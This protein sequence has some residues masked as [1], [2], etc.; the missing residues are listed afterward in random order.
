M[1]KK[2]AGI[3]SLA[4]VVSALLTGCGNSSSTT[5]K[6]QKSDTKTET[7]DEK[8]TVRVGVATSGFAYP[9]YIGEEK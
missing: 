5:E 2:I 3:V 9:F 6:T 7:T 8:T 4:L 1:K